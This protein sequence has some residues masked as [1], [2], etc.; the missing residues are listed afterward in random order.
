[1]NF[2]EYLRRSETDGG[3]LGFTDA[4][5]LTES[6]YLRAPGRPVGVAS[7]IWRGSREQ[8]REAYDWTLRTV[9]RAMNGDKWA[10]LRLQEALTTSDFGVLFGDVLDRSVLANYAE[11]PYSWSTYAKRATISDFRLAKIFRVD[12][13]AA[14]LD[15]PILPNTYGATG[16]GPTGL[17]QESEYPQRKRQATQYTD[18]LYKF[19]ARMDFAWETLIN[20]DL[21][22]LKDTPALFGRAARRTEEERATKLYCATTGPNATFFSNANKN[23]LNA[24]VL[25]TLNSVYGLPNNPPLSVTSLQCAMIVMMNQVDLDGEP[26][27]IEG[28]TLVVAPQNKVTGMSILNARELWM[29]DTGGT[30]AS[31]NSNSAISLQ[32]LITENWAKGMF[33]LA[34]NYY[35]NRVI[36]TGNIG[37]TAWFL[38]ADPNSGRPALQQSFLRGHEAPEMFMKSPN[39]IAIGEGRMGPGAGTMPGTQMANPMDGDFETDNIAYKIRHILGG[40]LLDPIVAV[41][42]SGASA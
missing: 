24:T 1:M 13:G 2:T 33:K 29:N 15:G 42:S 34:V 39:S 30:Y 7:G 14:V 3:R 32:R 17:E 8:Y 12:R 19:G 20:D 37:S 6:D 21:D 4:T 11:C 16:S 28:F 22:A 35:L 5:E 23:L 10:S 36:T 9:E 18:Q 31:P 26:I 27:S 25:P 40:T 41:A 38:F